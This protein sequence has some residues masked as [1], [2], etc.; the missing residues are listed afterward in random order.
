[1]NQTKIRYFLIGSINFLSGSIVFAALLSV[2]GENLNYLEILII[3]SLINILISHTY[4]RRFVWQSKNSYFP[5]LK[6]FIGVNIPPLIFNLTILPLVIETW[7]LPIL[8]TQLWTSA[9]IIV[10]TFVVHKS[11]TFK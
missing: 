1:M 10:G 11:W 9:L 7:N 8:P 5:E 2:L 6:K 3:S 4:Q